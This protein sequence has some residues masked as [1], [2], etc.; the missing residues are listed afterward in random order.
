MSSIVKTDAI[1]LKA[2]KYREASKIVTFYTR[3]FGKI[4]AI[5]KGARRATSKYGSSL[6]PLSY[7]SLVLYKKEGREIQTLSQCDLMK[8]FRHLY[9][10]LDKMAAGMAILELVTVVTHEQ[11]KNLPLFNL[12]VESLTAVNNATKNPSSLLY[13][14]EF[15]LARVLGFQPS[16]G[17]CISCGK[18]VVREGADRI[19]YHLE[20]GGPLCGSCGIVPGS[21]ITLNGSVFQL[22]SRMSLNTKVT[23]DVNIEIDKKS[24]REIENFLRSFLQF[25]VSGIRPLKSEKVFLK[26]FSM[27]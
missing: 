15:Q 10:D 2:I 6:D 22:L 21:K 26:I 9:E 8:S 12:L 5:A 23:T 16:F 13:V 17:N 24:Q 4:S 3:Q 18:P 20:Q 27:S 11:E 19:E 25:H 14:F 7:V 1:V